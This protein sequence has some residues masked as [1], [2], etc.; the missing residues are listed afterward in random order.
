MI[1]PP[2]IHARIPSGSVA[3]ADVEDLF[4]LKENAAA[5]DDTNDHRDSKQHYFFLSCVSITQSP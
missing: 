5:D 4:C 2:M 3:A 1:T